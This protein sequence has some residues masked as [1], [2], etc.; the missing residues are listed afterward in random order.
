MIIKGNNLLALH[1]L[2]RKFA[3]KV[4]LIYID[5]PYNTCNDSFKYNDK[6]SQSTWLT[7]MKNR[8][9][10]ARELL[11]ETGSIFISI[12][13][14]ELGYLLVLMDEIFD[15]KNRRN[16]ITVKRSAIS[17]AKV[18]NP[19]VVNVSEYIIVYSKS[20]S[21]KC[22]KIQIKKNR[23]KRYNRF[24]ENIE[25]HYS[26]W[27]FAT[28][29]DAFSDAVKVKKNKLKKHFGDSYNDRLE[30]FIQANVDKIIQF[31]NLDK[32][33]IKDEV[34]DAMERSRQEPNKIFHV[35]RENFDD[36]YILNGQTI[37]FYKNRTVLQNGQAI[38]VEPLSDIWTD[39][40]LNNLHNEG[41]VKL[42]K[43][44]KA[45]KMI[46]RIIE[47]ATDEEDLV[48]DFF[49]GSGTACAVAHKMKRQYIGIEQ[50]EYGEN[51]PKQRLINTIEGE[52]SGVSKDF[53]WTG[54]GEFV[55]AELERRNDKIAA[56]IINAKIPSTLMKIY[57]NMRAHGDLRHDID[58][59]SFNVANFTSLSLGE[60]KK[61]LLECLDHNHLYV[62]LG[63]MDD[64]T[65]GIKD[66]DRRINHDF[67]GIA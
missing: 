56:M 25:Q 5:P 67:Y 12:D 10:A 32:S 4:Q 23:D 61:L 11:H 19:G 64:E 8:L 1:S 65:Y 15:V 53:G 55:H 35:A 28:L 20:K 58:M 7:F 31:A 29:L 62:N 52:Q 49:T 9:E 51:S 33:K 16:I 39:V 66:G 46:A 21:W 48:L 26:K 2:K 40:T 13:H 59:D 6:F 47:L 63:D 18:I 57:N 41:R 22:N 17:G 44:K 43:G 3:G 27:T 34:V 54:G 30:K 37:L 38:Q 45:E 24:I 36:Y 14:N 42:K 60:Q 50:M